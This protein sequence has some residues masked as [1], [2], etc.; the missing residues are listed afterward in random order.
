MARK[1]KKSPHAPEEFSGI[2][3][4]VLSNVEKATPDQMLEIWE[5]WD[6]AVGEGIAANA[7]PAAFKKGIL[8]VTVASAAFSQELLYRERE[9]VDRLNDYLSQP[10]VTRLRSK[11]G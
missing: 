7:R 8:I 5:H 4:R 9:I 6:R 3:A 2:L 10:I 11:V 1:R